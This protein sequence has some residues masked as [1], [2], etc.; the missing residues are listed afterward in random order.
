MTYRVCL[1]I[2]ED[3]SAESFG[4]DCPQESVAKFGS[5]DDAYEYAC[6]L[7]S[8]ARRGRVDQVP[9][10]TDGN[11]PITH[12]GGPDKIDGAASDGW[13]PLS[14]IYNNADNNTDRPPTGT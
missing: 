2:E 1:V 9:G 5:H 11:P 10:L 7:I 13:I 14:D 6:R 4:V 3:D 8:A 12:D